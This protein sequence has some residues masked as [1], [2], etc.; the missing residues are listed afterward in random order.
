LIDKAKYFKSGATK[1]GSNSIIAR[2]EFRKLIY[3]KDAILSHNPIGDET[4][5]NAIT[6]EDLKDYYNRNFSP[7]G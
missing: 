5:I 2:I 1:R 6:L 4:T 7:S 3:G